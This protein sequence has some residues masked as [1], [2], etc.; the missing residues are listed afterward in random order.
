MTETLEDQSLETIYI[1][2]PNG[3]KVTVSADNDTPNGA[4][5]TFPDLKNSMNTDISF[6]KS[7]HDQNDQR[8][9]RISLE[10]N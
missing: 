9:P 3:G 1:A 4:Q 6:Q 8:S 7:W 2:T 10:K 5:L